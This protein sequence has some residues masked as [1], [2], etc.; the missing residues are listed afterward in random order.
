L[1]GKNSIEKM[2]LRGSVWSVVAD[3]FIT[4]QIMMI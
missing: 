2:G 1:G 3:K 4:Y